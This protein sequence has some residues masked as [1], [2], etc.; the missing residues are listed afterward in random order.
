MSFI[1]HIKE[2]VQQL[3]AYNVKGKPL[4]PDLIKLNQNENPF[5]LPEELKRELTEEFF[6]FHWNRYPE[7]LP[8]E[9]IHALADSFRFPAEGILAANGSNEL[10]YTILM[11]IVGRG[12]NVVIPSPTFFLYEKIVHI[13]EGT[14]VAVPMNSDLSFNTEAIILSA[15]KSRASLVILN[16]PNSPTGQS[17]TIRDVERVLQETDAI[18]LVDEAYIEFSDHPSVFSLLQKYDR[19][20]LLRTFSK[21]FSL[22]GLR[23]GYLFAQP[24]LCAEIMK[25]KI[26]F[27]VNNFSQAAAVK[28]LQ[29]QELVN[30]RITR[31]KQAKNILYERMKQISEITV[32]HSDT[33]F[34]I[35]KV[36]KNAQTLFEKL[37]AENVLIRD[38][39]S[40]P[41]LNNTLRVNSGTKAENE[42]FISAVQNF[43]IEK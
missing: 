7:V 39:S 14:V 19:L 43:F 12:T 6:S 9:F 35:F 15:K 10:M 38:V 34:L 21:A 26:P 33:N 22:A 3:E 36:K 16:S 1:H 40:Y 27:T 5:D 20:I 41:M 23:I 2:S 37:L 29:R 13:L 11:A 42:A 25:P 17:M 18:V 32:F 30:E 4:S 28:L 24:A 8:A 31:I